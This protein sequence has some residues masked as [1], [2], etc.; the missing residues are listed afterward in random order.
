MAEK[1]KNFRSALKKGATVA[2]LAMAL[3]SVV[4]PSPQP[5]IQNYNTASDYL[6]YVQQNRMNEAE[7]AEQ[8]NREL[9]VVAKGPPRPEDNN[10]IGAYKVS[11]ASTAESKSEQKGINTKS[12]KQTLASSAQEEKKKGAKKSNNQGQQRGR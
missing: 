8:A 11:L 4:N 1:S 12:F 9:K 5:Q 2:N 6:D 7:K 10:K 3:S